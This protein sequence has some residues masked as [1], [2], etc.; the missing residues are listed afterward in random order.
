MNESPTP[1]EGFLRRWARLKAKSDPA[2][3]GAA[4]PMDDP[5]QPI[6]HCAVAPAVPAS[7]PKRQALTL[8]DVARLTPQ[9]DYSAF[10]AGGVDP[11]VRR[12]ALRKLFADPNFAV[13]DGLDIYIDDYTKASP[14]TDAMLASL[15]HAPG[16]LTRL[17][18]KNDESGLQDLAGPAATARSPGGP[19]L[20]VDVMP[21]AHAGMP[22]GPGPSP[23]A[24]QSPQSPQSP[25][26][27][28]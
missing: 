15:S 9:S 28:P 16:V 18:G 5:A 1:K 25:Q 23:Q 12:L 26:G 7:A 27:N 4:R 3:S 24:P 11:A 2:L 21:V 20:D 22:Q 8:E 13:M 19:A 10:V 14:L 6:V 17:L